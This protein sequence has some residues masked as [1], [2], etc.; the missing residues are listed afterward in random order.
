MRGVAAGKAGPVGQLR[1]QG[2][3]L[4]QIALQALGHRH[5]LGMGGVGQ[6]GAGLLQVVALG[7]DDG[8][9]AQQHRVQRGQRALVMARHQQVVAALEPINVA[10]P[11][12]HRLVLHRV[13]KAAQIVEPAFPA[14]AH[15]PD[16]QA[17]GPEHLEKIRGPGF[18]LAAIVIQPAGNHHHQRLGLGRQHGRRRKVVKLRL[19]R[20]RIEPPGGVVRHAEPQHAGQRLRAHEVELLRR[21]DVRDHRAMQARHLQLAQAGIVDVEGHIKARRLAKAHAGLLHQISL[22]A[23]VLGQLGRVVVQDPAPGGLVTQH[24]DP[25]CR[26]PLACTALSLRCVGAVLALC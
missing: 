17:A 21:V 11:V 13:A 4:I 24:I 15:H 23:Q 2:L 14:R 5:Q 10:R 6:D 8:H 22:A 1:M 12:K 9:H 25:H 26:S 20:Q 16:Q 7:G 19:A 18:V 3:P